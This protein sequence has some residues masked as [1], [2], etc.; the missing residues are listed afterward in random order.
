MRSTALVLLGF[1]AT[2]AAV[3]EEEMRTIERRFDVTAEHRVFLDLPL[4][5]IQVEA[6]AP[7]RAEI[8]I[9]VSC[10][11]DSGRCR[12][13]AEE[14]YLDAAEHQRSLSLEIRG[15]SNRLTRRP[16]VE[17][18]LRL[19]G[20]TALEIDLGVGEVYMT[21]LRGDVE[22]DLGVGEVTIFA[23]EEAVGELRLSVG[24]GDIDLQP[25][26]RTQSDSGFLFLGN[27]LRWNDGPG[28]AYFAIDVGVGEI[29]V[30]L[31]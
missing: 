12:E 2:G 26:R 4:G 15:L 20:D 24:V 10:G 18:H 29:N 3:A 5:T 9:I 11:S 7:G 25:R 19:P 22:V 13:R 6:G 30:T 16:S 23:A 27:E 14:I 17:V 28:S 21:D 31:D 1:L 8:E